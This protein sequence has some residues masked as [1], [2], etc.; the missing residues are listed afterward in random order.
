MY[1]SDKMHLKIVI[2]KKHAKY[3][4]LQ[5]KSQFSTFFRNNF[6]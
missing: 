3:V 5:K 6:I 2:P 4:L 1:F